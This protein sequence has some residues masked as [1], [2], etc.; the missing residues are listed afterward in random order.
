VPRALE[1]QLALQRYR[2]EL[3]AAGFRSETQSISVEDA[4]T[5][6]EA[7]HFRKLAITPRFI[8]LW[9]DEHDLDRDAPDGLDKA[10]QGVLA[11]L[12]GKEVWNEEKPVTRLTTM[13]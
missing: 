4:L 7:G 8:L 9:N 10:I 5:R 6:F 13:A 1:I 3:P 12:D 11:F 2:G